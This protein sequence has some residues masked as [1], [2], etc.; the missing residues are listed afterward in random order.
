M[1][2]AVIAYGWPR[3]TWLCLDEGYDSAP[4]IIA[5][6]KFRLLGCWWS[7]AVHSICDVGYAKKKKNARQRWYVAEAAHIWFIDV[8]NK[9]I[10]IIAMRMHVSHFATAMLAQKTLYIDR[11][12]THNDNFTLFSI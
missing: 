12:E 4:W 5:V 7:C 10:E 2:P 6:Y 11:Y 1:T 3:S 9:R 8:S